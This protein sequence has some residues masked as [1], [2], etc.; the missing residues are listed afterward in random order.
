VNFDTGGGKL[1]Q[2]SRKAIAEL[3]RVP[4]TN[5]IVDLRHNIGGDVGLTAD[6]MRHIASNTPGRIFVLTGPETLSAAMVSA[7]FL[8]KH[9][10]DRTVLVGD[11][12]GDHLRFWSEIRPVCLPNSKLCALASTGLWDLQ[13]GCAG[14]PGCYK[15]NSVYDA[16]VEDLKPQVRAPLTVE[17]YLKKRDPAMEAVIAQIRARLR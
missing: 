10:G 16:V 13:K 14:E 4:P 8:K 1:A 12:V 17:T 5:V 6:L 3:Q 9:G 15:D 7:A 2:F 11:D